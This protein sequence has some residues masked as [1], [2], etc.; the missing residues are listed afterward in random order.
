[1]KEAEAEVAT[2]A[3]DSSHFAGPVVMVDVQPPTRFI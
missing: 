2:S 3:K 1:L